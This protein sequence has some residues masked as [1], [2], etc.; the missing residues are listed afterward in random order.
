MDLGLH[1]RVALVTGASRGI[2]FGIARALAAEGASV[3]MSS[4]TRERIE[5]AAAEIG[6]RPYVHDNSDLD[7]APR[8][9]GQVGQELGPVEVLVLNTGGPPGR[10]PLLFN[11][12]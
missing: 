5:S 9:V 12:A 2:G 6:G 7:G 8:L 11:L 1:G 10:V 3:A 4:P